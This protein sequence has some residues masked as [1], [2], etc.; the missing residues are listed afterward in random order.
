MKNCRL[1][2][3]GRSDQKLDDVPVWVTVPCKVPCPWPVSALKKGML[4]FFAVELFSVRDLCQLKLC[5]LKLQLN[6]TVNIH[7]YFTGDSYI[8]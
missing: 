1:Y 5:N 3:N 8:V 7:G 4:S 2:S 6:S